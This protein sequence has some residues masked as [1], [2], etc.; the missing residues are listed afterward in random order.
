MKR[1]LQ[2]QIVRFGLERR[3]RLRKTLVAIVGVTVILFGLVLIV[4]PG[5]AALVIPLGVAILATEFAWAR[6]VWQR[7]KIF[8]EK[9][10]RRGRKALK[11]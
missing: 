10:K 8:I 9:A 2:R 1:F 6:R 5:P 7:G 11:S 4:T 3:P